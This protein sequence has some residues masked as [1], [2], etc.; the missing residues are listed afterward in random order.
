MSEGR[1]RFCRLKQN[2]SGGVSHCAPGR[3]PESQDGTC[4]WHVFFSF[5]LLFLNTDMDLLQWKKQ[6]PMWAVGSPCETGHGAGRA[7][8]CKRWR[9]FQFVR[10]MEVEKKRMGGKRKLNDKESSVFERGMSLKMLK[11]HD[12]DC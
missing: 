3:R 2:G 1:R 7:K 5:L 8:T 6:Q 4:W 10:S 12:Q 11:K 9:K